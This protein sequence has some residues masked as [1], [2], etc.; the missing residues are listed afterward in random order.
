MLRTVGVHYT[1]EKRLGCG[2]FGEL[3]QGKDLRT[4]KPIAVKLESASA[5]HPQLFYEQ[6]LYRAFGGNIGVPTVHWYGEEDNYNIM[7]MDLMG[8]SLEDLFESC[9]RRFSLPC[10]LK[11]AD[12]MI[13]RLEYVHSKHFLHRDI[14]PEN[15]LMG[16]GKEADR[17]YIIDFG[18]AKKY[19]DRNHREHIPYREGKNMIGTA[20]YASLGAHLGFEQGRRDDLEALGYVLIYFLK[21]RLPWQGLRAEN[22]AQKNQMITNR[23]IATVGRALCNDCPTEFSS[24]F[25]Y[26]R[27]LRFEEKPDYDYLRQLFKDLFVRSGFTDETKFDWVV[28]SKQGQSKSGDDMG[29]FP[30]DLQSGLAKRASVPVQASPGS[31]DGHCQD[32]KGRDSFQYTMEHQTSG[33]EDNSGGLVDVTKDARAVRAGG[34]SNEAEPV[35][36]A[37]AA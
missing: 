2:A 35:A 6:R 27:N 4:Q 8:P 29:C 22:E 24:Y 1:L 13:S 30:S 36:V 5:R 9:G 19:R 33:S 28:A 14:K 18:L 34:Y 17:V 23:K 25:Q 10:V 11:L 16:V 32:T 12:Q 15:F 37:A 3:Y 7:V 21:G 31:M 26:C 20:R